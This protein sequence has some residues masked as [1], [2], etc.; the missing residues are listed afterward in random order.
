MAWVLGLVIIG[1]LVYLAY[2]S[3][4]A[5]KA[6]IIVLAVVLCGVAY[7]IY[8]EFVS[9]EQATTLIKPD[10]VELREFVATT[11]TGIFYARGSIKNLS[12]AHTL[13]FLEIRVR[14]HDCPSEQLVDACEIVGESVEKI[15]IEIPPGQ[16]RGTEKSVSFSNLPAVTNLVWSFDVAAVRAKV[17]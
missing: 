2:S 17:D 1:G 8:D 16:V 7:L 5:R 4:E 14:A 9:E 15:K 6:V 11:R 3:P 10:E 13:E 12:T